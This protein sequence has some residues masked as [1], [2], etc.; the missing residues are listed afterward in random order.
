MSDDPYLRRYDVTRGF[1]AGFLIRRGAG[2]TAA[3]LPFVFDEEVPL[4]ATILVI[5]VIV[6]LAVWVAAA[7]R[8]AATILYE[9]HILIRTAFTTRRV[10]WEDVQ[11]IRNERNPGADQHNL[12]K[13][14]MVLY[15][16]DGRRL[17]LPHLSEWAVDSLDEELRVLRD[18][19]TRR[20]GE[21]W[22]QL[23]EVTTKLDAV[24]AKSE[25]AAEQLGLLSIAVGGCAVWPVIAVFLILGLN[26]DVLDGMSGNVMAVVLVGTFPAVSLMV[27]VP[28]ALRRRRRRT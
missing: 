21:D 20:R 18:M 10:A 17:A 6:L 2:L 1:S 8:R 24:T 13:S 27:Y 19:W 22:A 7:Y 16:R 26:T 15:D 4:W 28:L 11:E 5:A 14:V 12:P 9:D 23:P 25:R 3:A